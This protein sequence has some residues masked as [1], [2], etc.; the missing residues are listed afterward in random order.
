[1]EKHRKRS[2]GRPR[3]KNWIAAALLLLVLAALVLDSRVHLQV[4]V[5]ELSFDRLPAGMDGLRVVH[6]SDLH[7]M[8]FGRDNSRLTELVRLQRPDLIA[9][10]GD[11]AEHEGHLPAVE[12]LLRGLAPLAPV[13]Y[14]SGNHEWAGGVL[15]QVKA[16]ME[17][18]GAV[19]LE[20]EFFPFEKNGASILI[21]GVEDPNG[22]ADMIRPDAL[23][24]SLRAR[25]PDTFVLW[26]GH[27]NY[28]VK[29]YGTLP[30]DLI[31]CG[32]A[33]GGV[34]RLPLIGGLLNTDV[35]FG[36]EYEAGVYSSGSFL[37][38]VSRGLGNSIP[39]PRFLNRPEV[40]TLILRSGSA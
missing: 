28:W 8:E 15:P 7:G 13:Y 11:L 25:Y 24:A 38:E 33:H 27:R 17:R 9:L 30:V 1:M 36:A 40:V 20:N 22:W 23:A 12:S 29:R 18:Y 34:V 26:L 32:H 2:A 4:T 14:V 31:L 3:R 35:S 10:T 39:I 19:C 5:R 37:M 21:A 16:L 6:L